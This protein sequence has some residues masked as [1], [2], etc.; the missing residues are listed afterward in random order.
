MFTNGVPADL[1][2]KLSVFVYQQV[3]QFYGVYVDVNIIPDFRAFKKEKFKGQ[4]YSLFFFTH[5]FIILSVKEPSIF[6][7]LTL[8]C[9]FSITSL[10]VCVRKSSKDR[11]GCG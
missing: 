8:I 4:K 5:N 11:G 7:T 6:L 9:C 1:V 3:G 2:K 10:C